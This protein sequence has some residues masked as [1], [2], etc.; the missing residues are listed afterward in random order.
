MTPLVKP[1]A[2]DICLCSGDFTVENYGQLCALHDKQKSLI[3]P[4][5]SIKVSSETRLMIVYESGT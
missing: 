4:N 1:A 5:Q 3:I 2:A